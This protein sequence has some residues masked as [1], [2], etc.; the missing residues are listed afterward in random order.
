LKEKVPAA[1]LKDENTAV[2]I[3]H[4]DQLY[5]QKVGINFA[6]KRGSSVGII[7]SRTQATEFSFRVL[8]FYKENC[9]LINA[10]IKC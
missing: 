7:R 2:E 6:D 3:R 9:K 4:V 1:I 8:V 5:P 10:F